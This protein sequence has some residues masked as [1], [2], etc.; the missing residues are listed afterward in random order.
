VVGS[1]EDILEGII[2][3][4][5]ADADII[6]MSLGSYELQGLGVGASE[7]SALRIAVGRATTYAFQNGT[8][9]IVSAGNNAVNLDGGGSLKR[10]MG[11]LPHTISISATAPIGWALDPS[12]DLDV[13]TS[14]SNYGF[15]GVEFAAPGGDSA[16]PGNENCLVGGLVRPCWVFDL[17]FSAAASDGVNFFSGWAGG[18]SMAAPHAAGIAAL[19][20]GENGGS[21]NPSQVRA[22]LEARADD[23]GAA[24]D[25][26]LYG[27]GRVSSGH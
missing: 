13:F 27:R 21:M 10:F 16:Y 1:F 2:Y 7:I 9:V 19:I 12:T 14:Y 23:L 24:G 15:S 3:A 20:I 17:V 18:T 26:P 8:T 6:N 4:T 22:E 11:D 25:D 5:N